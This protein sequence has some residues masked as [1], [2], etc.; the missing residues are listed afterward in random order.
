MLA[1]APGEQLLGPGGVAAHGFQL[2]KADQGQ[3]AAA[4]DRRRVAAGGV[5]ALQ[6]LLEAGGGGVEVAGGA[7]QQ[8]LLEDQVG[9]LGEEDEALLGPPRRLLAVAADAQALDQAG[10]QRGQVAELGP[11]RVPLQQ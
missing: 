4:A 3:V 10:A 7:G 8:C 6:A 1:Q 11:P 2:G 9:Q 5:A